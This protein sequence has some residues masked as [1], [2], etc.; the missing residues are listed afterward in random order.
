MVILKNVALPRNSLFSTFQTRPTRPIK[1]WKVRWSTSH[2]TIFM[3]DEGKDNGLKENLTTNHNSLDMKQT[4]SESIGRF[5][6]GCDLGDGP[7]VPDLEFLEALSTEPFA[8]DNDMTEQP[9]SNKKGTLIGAI[10]LI[11]GT[12]IGSGI[13]ALPASTAPAGFI[14]SA[15]SMVICWGFLVFEALLLAEVN[16]TLL[17]QQ[18]PSHSK[19]HESEVISLRT[20]AEKTLGKWGGNVS[21]I[22]YIF[23]SYTIMVAY[24]TK[25]GEILSYIFRIPA[26]I[27]GALFACTFGILLLVGGTKLT[28]KVNQLLAACLIG[29]PS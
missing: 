19:K 23:L 28:D 13:L 22:S 10:S 6:K 11:T 20:M 16:V 24:I 17:K 18:D 21:T 4:P 1:G 15:V 27:A 9:T 29:E 7:R 8:C 26:S 3:I 14:P 12:C 2:L 25:S 5:D